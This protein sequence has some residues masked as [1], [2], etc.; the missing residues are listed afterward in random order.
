MVLALIA[1]RGRL[2]AAVAAAQPV[3][4]LVCALEGTA[5]EGL[6]PDITFRIE[7]LGTLLLTLGERGVTEVCLC[8]AIDRPAIDPARLDAETLP[9]VPLFQQALARGD[10]GALR[11]VMELFEK[12][13]F[14]IRAAHELAPDLTPPAGVPTRAQPQPTHRAD[15]QEALMVLAEQGRSD[16]GQACVVRRGEV[17]AREDARGTDAM[18]AGLA[19]PFQ[20]PEAGDPLSWA[21]DATGALL[22]SAADWLSGETVDAHEAPGAG[23]ILFKAPKPGQDR[24]ADLPTIGPETAMRAAEAGLDGIVLEAGGV[25]VLDRP[26][27][28]AILDAMGMFLWLR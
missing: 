26:Q 3:P 15:V 13:G 1:G 22:Q 12:T 18:L 4:P 17:L 7:T 19:L 8:G 9:L 20:R 11:L 23:A 28:V 5:P 24:R 10:D 27:V 16:L 6:A 21:F 2:P 25:I 14:A